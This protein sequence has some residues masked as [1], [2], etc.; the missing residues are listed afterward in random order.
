VG[1]RG[2]RQIAAGAP[3]GRKN[4]DCGLVVVALK[5]ELARRPTRQQNDGWA[6]S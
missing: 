3:I 4:I 5:L 6:S 2:Y 1:G